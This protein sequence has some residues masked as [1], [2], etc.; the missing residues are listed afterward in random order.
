MLP[1]QRHPVLAVL[2][3]LFSA[4]IAT[5]QTGA[6]ISHANDVPGFGG[7]VYDC[8]ETTVV[9]TENESKRLL[10]FDIEGGAWVEED[11]DFYQD[12]LYVA[13]EGHLALAVSDT[14]AVAY[15]GLTS[16]AHTIRYS[17]DRLNDTTYTW[18]YRCGE[19]LAYLATD[20]FFY[21]FDPELDAWQQTAV[22]IPANFYRCNSFP[23]DDYVA[24]MMECTYGNFATGYAYSSSAHDFA[25]TTEAPPYAHLDGVLNHGFAE[26]NN[27]G[28]DPAFVG[29]SS[30]TNTFT[31][32]DIPTAYTQLQYGIADHNGK[33]LRTTFGGTCGD[34]S[35]GYVAHM[36]GYDTRLGVWTHDE[37]VFDWDTYSYWYNKVKGGQ[38]FMSVIELK[39]TN[40]IGYKVY[41]G[42]DGTITTYWPGHFQSTNYF[43]AGGIALVT[44]DDNNS[45]WGL[46]TATGDNLSTSVAL[47]HT[48]GLRTEGENFALF[49]S[50]D[51][52]RTDMDL[53]AYHAPTNTWA[54]TTAYRT[55]TLHDNSGAHVYCRYGTET[56]LEVTFYSGIHGA[57]QQLTFADT[58]NPRLWRSD[59][60]S[61]VE[62]DGEDGCLYDAHRD[63]LS[64]YSPMNYD[65]GDG[66]G[67]ACFVGVDPATQFAW[68]YSAATGNWTEAAIGDTP[69][70]GKAGNYVG[71]CSD[72]WPSHY[73]LAFNGFHDTWVPLDTIGD[74]SNIDCGGQTMM[75]YHM[76][77]V[78]AFDPDAPM[79][80]IEIQP[81]PLPDPSLPM[82]ALHPVVPN[83]FNPQATV[84][85][86]LPRN[87]QVQLEVYDI[88]GRKVRTLVEGTW[89]AGRHEVV[90]Q[91]DGDDG[92]S[93]PSGTYLLRLETDS[94]VMTRQATLLK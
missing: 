10:F 35:S 52:V 33:E 70:V 21:V 6:W 17:G 75:T 76:S 31:K 71:W 34:Y 77:T 93:L 57:F 43:I 28:T 53:T 46:N 60:L 73:I 59:W 90:W 16:T 88:R 9:F 72:S 50:F 41:S 11:F 23:G 24:A 20:E 2:F 42:V 30:V 44:I 67:Q 55:T 69:R 87:E 61:F 91:G 92:R 14:F 86:D 36:W 78:W 4:T 49:S 68:G 47:D 19:T 79:V 18:S 12:W 38:Y 15:N 40:E 29:Y 5:A 80:G 89:T 84:A 51:Y 32:E 64:T 1:V 7:T 39:D 63:N 94:R 37:I 26:F 8:G 27:V 83:P 13:A 22:V 56:N 45:A 65:F 3:L 74:I 48:H 66:I 54:T 62:T 58:P 25:Y 81:D 82:L 85:F